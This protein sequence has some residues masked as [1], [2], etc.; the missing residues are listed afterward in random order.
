M[1]HR[2]NYDIL[3]LFSCSWQE[4]KI[5]FSVL[6]LKFQWSEEQC[7]GSSDLL[8]VALYSSDFLKGWWWLVVSDGTEIF[9]CALRVVSTYIYVSEA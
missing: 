9:P 5:G 6:M 7:L 2:M 8:L 1:F 3:H 4:K